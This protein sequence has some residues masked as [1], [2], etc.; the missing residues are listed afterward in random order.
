MRPAN[1]SAAAAKLQSPRASAPTPSRPAPI[2]DSDFE[3]GAAKLENSEHAD[4]APPR[5]LPAPGT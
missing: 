3:A 2:V 4:S 1:T 5:M